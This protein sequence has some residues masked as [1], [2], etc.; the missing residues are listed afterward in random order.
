MV[1]SIENVEQ[2]NSQTWTGCF[3]SIAASAKSVVAAPFV[4]TGKEVLNGNVDKINKTLQDKFSHF[5]SEVIGALNTQVT[6]LSGEIAN[7][8]QIA[9]STFSGNPPA[10]DRVINRFKLIRK[11]ID[12]RVQYNI[13]DDGATSYN[14]KTLVSDEKVYSNIDGWYVQQLDTL[15]KR[16][17]E[18]LSDELQEQLKAEVIA[19][20][21]VVQKNLDSTKEDLCIAYDQHKDDITSS[22]D[23]CIKEITTLQGEDNGGV[24]SIKENV[25][26][27]EGTLYALRNKYFN[28]TQNTIVQLGESAQQLQQAAGAMVVTAGNADQFF[29]KTNNVLPG[30]RVK[31]YFT[32]LSGIGTA[33]AAAIVL[34]N[35]NTNSPLLCNFSLNNRIVIISF[36]LL[37]TSIVF[38]LFTSYSQ[39]KLVESDL[40]N[41]ILKVTLIGF[42]LIASIIALIISLTRV[43]LPNVTPACS[44]QYH[45]IPAES[46]IIAISAGVALV[47]LLSV[48]INGLYHIF[49]DRKQQGSVEQPDDVPS[50]AV[51]NSICSVIKKSCPCIP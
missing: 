2:K 13:P 51:G 28:S 26:K 23:G 34:F 25:G 16:E 5:T 6:E 38:L 12:L 27:A 8:G 20:L 45:S 4:Y 1:G 18:Q 32:Y 7:V 40:Y 10:L 22:F 49:P 35:G 39:A 48:A 50:S 11:C 42:P 3:L 33:V 24:D 36:A 17:E 19:A 31:F 29:N 9:N 44:L 14:V 41:N 43:F 30:S 47:A 15:N 46:M 21:K 37:L